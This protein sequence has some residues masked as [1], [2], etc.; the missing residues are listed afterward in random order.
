[1]SIQLFNSE[2][3][4]FLN[5]QQLPSFNINLLLHLHKSMFS[6]KAKLSFKTANKLMLTWKVQSFS[7]D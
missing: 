4:L 1:M 5:T 6:F 2:K 3:L 7:L